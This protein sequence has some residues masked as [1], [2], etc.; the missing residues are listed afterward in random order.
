MNL[1]T[2]LL[3]IISF[4]FFI[5]MNSVSW[6]RGHSGGRSSYSHSS[7]RRSSGHHRSSSRPVHVRS[8]RR[9]NGTYV[10]SHYR[11]MPRRH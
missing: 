5:M 1:A 2:R 11:S 7:Y 8:Y 10:H 3:L 6:A 4:S 9:K